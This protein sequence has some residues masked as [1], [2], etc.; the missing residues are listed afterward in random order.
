MSSTVTFARDNVRAE[1]IAGEGAVLSNL[2]IDGQSVLAKTPWTVSPAT[3]PAP[4]EKSWVSRWR[5]G[6]QLCAPNTGSAD[7]VTER[8]AFHGAAS[9]ANWNIVEQ[10]DKTLKL[11]WMDAEGEIELVREWSFNGDSSVSVQTTATNKSIAKKP[12]GFAEHL[13]LGSRF[14][15]PVQQGS[16]AKLTLCPA[17]KILDLDYSGAPTGLIIEPAA[18]KD[19][20][21]LTASQPAK[22]FVVSGSKTNSISVQ[23][24]DWV[25]R[26]EW[27]G[28]E[29][30]LVWQE[31]GTSAEAPWSSE[32]FALGIEPTN[33][34]HGLGA[35]IEVGPFLLPGETITWSTSVQFFRKE[36]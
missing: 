23:V 36:D 2:E 17:S 27:Q 13:I 22:V 15:Q 20:T 34:P 14:L 6:W 33:V 19:F 31:F 25:A 30:A 9:Q 5:G 32:V 4:D 35:N 21:E 3:T 11:S 16:V 29:H 18:I 8:A 10:T 28:F 24:D 12:V 1:I 26:V 7:A